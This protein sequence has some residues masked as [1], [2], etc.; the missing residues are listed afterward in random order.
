MAETFDVVAQRPTT[1]FIGGTQTKDVVFV[2]IVTKPSNIYVGF[3][4]PQKGYGESVVNAAA[5]SWSTVFETV[6]GL[7]GVSGVQWAEL[8]NDSGYLYP[9]VIITVSSTSGDSSIPL[10]VPVYQLGPQDHQ[11]QILALRKKLDQTEN[12]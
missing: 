10:T 8:Q 5:L 4:V 2:G 11:P 6:A 7:T 9:A 12:L 3:Y 1:Q